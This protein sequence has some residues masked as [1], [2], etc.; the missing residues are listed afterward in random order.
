MLSININKGDTIRDI[1]IN[2]T[3][4]VENTQSVLDANNYDDW[5]KDL[6]EES[7]IEVPELSGNTSVIDDLKIYPSKNNGWKIFT[8]AISA[9]ISIIESAVQLD[10]LTPILPINDTTPKY[11]VKGNETLRDIC[12]NETGTIDNY[13]SML[14]LNGFT[15]YVPV[16]A[17]GQIIQIPDYIATPDI[18]QVNNKITLQ[19]YPSAN[20]SI[21]KDK[22]NDF[23]TIFTASKNY[24]NGELAYFEDGEL[25][26]FDK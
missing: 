3:V 13:D 7:T 8:S 11:T 1:V 15:D 21:L 12:L 6:S 17:K 26:Y 4:S 25:Y 9:L 16:L 2:N 22:I 20:N 5:N 18:L 14:E 19:I 23:I 24:E 10:E